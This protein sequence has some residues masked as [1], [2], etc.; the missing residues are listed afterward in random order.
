MRQLRASAAREGREGKANYRGNTRLE[1][2]GNGTIRRFYMRL[3]HFSRSLLASAAAAGDRQAHL[4]LEQ[5]AGA[6]VHGFAD[7]AV[8]DGMAKAN[9]H[10]GWSALNRGGSGVNRT[11][12]APCK[13]KR[14]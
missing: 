14:E 10:G 2:S 13:Y 8:A 12:Q 7:L 11:E 6:L 3:N 4:D 1:S 9:V 5:R